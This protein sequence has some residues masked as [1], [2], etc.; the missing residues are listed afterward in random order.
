MRLKFHMSNEL[1]PFSATIRS[2][3]LTFCSNTNND[4]NSQGMR[5]RLQDEVESYNI[6]YTVWRC[7]MRRRG[8]TE[9]CFSITV[10]SFQ[11]CKMHPRNWRKC[12]MV[13][14]KRCNIRK[15]NLF[16]SYEVC[17]AQL[18][19]QFHSWKWC[20]CIHIIFPLKN[21]VVKSKK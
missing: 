18:P 8:V 19:S 21:G 1:R 20:E 9:C 15:C 5:K 17:I 3:S 6:Y 7:R 11:N 12:P 4:S 14:G 13:W 2:N 10:A 16:S